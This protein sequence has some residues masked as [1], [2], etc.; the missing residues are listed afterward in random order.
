MRRSLIA[1]HRPVSGAEEPLDPI[2]DRPGEVALGP[3]T[4]HDVVAIGGGFS[5]VT[6]DIF[7][8]IREPIAL[9]EQFGFV[10][11]TRVVPSGL[12]EDG[13]IIGAGALVHR[14][15]MVPSF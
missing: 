13:P 4:Q 14:K 8:M 12:S 10:T 5:R 2:H 7:D 9:R 11:K 15:E 6:P 1:R 3:V